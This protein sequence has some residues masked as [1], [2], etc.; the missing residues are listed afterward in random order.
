MSSRYLVDGIM[1]R[2]YYGTEEILDAIDNFRYSASE[3]DSD[4]CTFTIKSGNREVV[5]LPQYQE[6]AEL[7][8]I[9]GY[10]NTNE[11]TKRIIT[12]QDA[13]PTYEDGYV[14]IKITASEKGRNLKYASSDTIHKNTSLMGVTKTIA[15]SHGLT[16]FIEIP[17]NPKSG[18]SAAIENQSVESILQNL[19]NLG[20]GNSLPLNQPYYKETPTIVPI[21]EATQ[22]LKESM[23]RFREKDSLARSLYGKSFGELADPLTGRPSIQQI[24]IV[25]KLRDMK[26]Y[27]AIPQANKTDAH[28]LNELGMKEKGG[29]FIAETRDNNITVRRR[30]FNKKPYKTYEYGSGEGLLLHFE[31]DS[32]NRGKRGSS[33]NLGFG[34]WDSLGKR[35]MEGNSNAFNDVA[36][37]TLAKYQDMLD[38]YRELVKKAPGL[39][40]GYQENPKEIGSNKKFLSS[41]IIGAGSAIS[42]ETRVKKILKVPIFAVD[43][44]KVIEDNIKEITKISPNKKVVDANNDGIEDAFDQSSN[45][46][47]NSEL[48]RN[49][50]RATIVGDINLWPGQVI[51]IIGVGKKYSGNFYIRSVDHDLKSRYEC[52]LELTRVGNNIRSHK[53]QVSVEESGKDMNT[54]IGEGSTSE[55]KSLEIKNNKR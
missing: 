9:W 13:P 48:N 15:D 43:R 31:A 52:S 23:V 33:L 25:Q 6:K 37:A 19:D 51:T 38:N 11:T 47:N 3:E 30:D 54:Q 39:I 10:I 2:I 34:A 8:V 21:A 14:C 36:Q 55:K 17:T 50:F 29:P 46:R 12:I 18:K 28:I 44:L 4:E 5:D 53:D 24:N 32:K 22:L 27:P 26:K 41:N 49:L 45:L 40:L 7:T 16:P 20:E 1:V 35:Y 42:D